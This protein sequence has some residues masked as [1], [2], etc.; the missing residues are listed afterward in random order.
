MRTVSPLRM[1][2]PDVAMG[3]HRL[4]HTPHPVPE[5]KSTRRTGDEP[6]VHTGRRRKWL[7]KPNAGV[8]GEESLR[9]TFGKFLR[10]LL[11]E[12]KEKQV[13]VRLPAGA[14]EGS[15]HGG[16]LAPRST[17][18]EIQPLCKRP[19]PWG[20]S[21]I[22]LMSAL[23]RRAGHRA[24]GAQVGLQESPALLA[25]ISRCSSGPLR[26]AS[27]RLLQLSGAWSPAGGPLAVSDWSQASALRP[28]KLPRSHH[29]EG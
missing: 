2:C 21:A 23:M 27:L 1:L 9:N 12:L 19:R 5:A 17:V 26:R 4:G 16:S 8:A 24:R 20:P 18:T 14:T 28:W 13:G 3:S 7:W 11:S 6:G 29:L 10:I 15:R 25:G 22:R